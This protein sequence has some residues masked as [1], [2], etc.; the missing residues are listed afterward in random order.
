MRYRLRRSRNWPQRFGALVAIVVGSRRRQPC[1]TRTCRSSI[2]LLHDGSRSELALRTPASSLTRW[3]QPRPAVDRAGARHVKQLVAVYQHRSRSRKRRIW[4]RCPGSPISLSSTSLRV[5]LA[6]SL[7]EIA[8]ISR[9]RSLRR[10]ELQRCRA[11]SALEDIEA[12]VGLR[13]LGFS[14]G[15][16]LENLMPFALLQ[17]LEVFHAWGS[18]RVLDC[19]LSL[20]AS[21][22]SRREIRMRDRH[23]YRPRVGEL[24][25]GNFRRSATGAS[26]GQTG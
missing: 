2:T 1:L 7:R 23:E 26:P 21:L 25:D 13:F 6:R 4:N 18:T 8:D 24:V 3:E 14:D 19:D 17:Q 22:P 10:L 11:L 5:V 20:L 9:L 12:L 15:G 16:D